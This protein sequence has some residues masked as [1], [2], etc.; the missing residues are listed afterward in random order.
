MLIP[1]T[2][3][4][5][6]MIIRHQNDLWRVMN[7]VHVTPGNWRGMVQTKLRNLRSGTQTEYRFRSEDKPERVDAWNSL[8]H[9][10]AAKHPY[11]VTVIDLNRRVC[12]DGKFTWTI[13]RLQIRSDGLHFTP[14]GVQTWIAPWL[15]PQLANLAVY[16]PRFTGRDD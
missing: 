9:N 5:V 4:R 7:V 12:P 15:V 8:V 11:K 16:G 10:V 2:Q 6:G 14:E 3:L 1:A 13:G